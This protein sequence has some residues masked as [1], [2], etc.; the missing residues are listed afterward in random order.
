S[1]SKVGIAH[2]GLPVVGVSWFEANAYCRW[3]A[4]HWD[5][6]TE[7]KANPEVRPKDVRLPTEH[8]WCWAVFESEPDRRFPWQQSH[9]AAIEDPTGDD[10]A[11]Y[12]NIGKVLDRT[13]PIGLFPLGVSHPYGLNDTCGNVWE[14]QANYFDLSYRGLALR[15][16]AYATAHTDAGCK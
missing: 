8:E 7:A 15:G 12:A 2:R 11:P 4:H 6:L 13:S 5:K 3:L 1:D 9:R 14:W 16:G 10:L